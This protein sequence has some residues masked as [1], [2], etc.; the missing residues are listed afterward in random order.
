MALM[1]YWRNHPPV[2]VLVAAFCGYKPQPKVEAAN[3]QPVYEDMSVLMKMFPN[4][5]VQLPVARGPNG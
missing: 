2:H 3:S 1:D 5:G 4:D